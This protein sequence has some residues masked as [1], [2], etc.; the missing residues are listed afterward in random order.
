M[1]LE[2]VLGRISQRSSQGQ[3]NAQVV[4]EHDKIL[5]VIT[6]PEFHMFQV[7]GDRVVPVLLGTAV[8]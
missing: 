3:L 4:V 6:R 7:R 1:T 8:E 2:D 5:L